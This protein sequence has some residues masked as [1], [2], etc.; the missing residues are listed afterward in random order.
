M[1]YWPPEP[2]TYEPTPALFRWAERRECRPHHPD[3]SDLRAFEAFVPSGS[4][5]LVVIQA[6]NFH[7]NLAVDQKVRWNFPVGS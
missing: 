7:G 2:I 5:A 1:K 3:E 4:L 6:S